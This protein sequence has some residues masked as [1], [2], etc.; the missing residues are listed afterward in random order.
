[1]FHGSYGVVWRGQ[2]FFGANGVDPFVDGGF[3]GE[4]QF[5]EVWVGQRQW[6]VV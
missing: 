2:G 5:V 4:T 6:R 3:V 1:M